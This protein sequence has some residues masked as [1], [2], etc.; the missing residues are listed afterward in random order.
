V[1]VFSICV[2]VQFVNYPSLSI[3]TPNF[4]II[5]QNW[6]DHRVSDL[7]GLEWLSLLG[8]HGALQNSPM[9]KFEFLSKYS[10]AQNQ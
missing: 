7:K 6:E 5:C 2:F 8:D 3:H 4:D 10:P 9:R 1:H